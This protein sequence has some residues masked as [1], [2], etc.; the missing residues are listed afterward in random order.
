[1]G[2]LRLSRLHEAGVDDQPSLQAGNSETTPREP[3]ADENIS[4]FRA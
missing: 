3:A 1:M 4:G 2:D